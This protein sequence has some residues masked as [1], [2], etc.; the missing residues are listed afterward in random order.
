MVPITSCGVPLVMSISLTVPALATRGGDGGAAAS[1]AADSQRVGAVGQL[2]AV[3]VLAV[4]VEAVV[5]GG[6]RAGAGI[7]GLAAGI[8]DGERGAGGGGAQIV[9]PVGLR[10]WSARPCRR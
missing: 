6:G 9:V 10:R 4:P 5:A 8:G 7:D 1:V 3:I 2:V